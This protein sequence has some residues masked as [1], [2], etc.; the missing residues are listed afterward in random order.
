MNQIEY[1]DIEK[2]AQANSSIIDEFKNFK[3][4][5]IIGFDSSKEF[6]ESDIA[7]SAKTS[8]YQALEIIHA[9]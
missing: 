1:M 5:M 4:E 2:V 3:V 9:C 6:N 7:L 8:F